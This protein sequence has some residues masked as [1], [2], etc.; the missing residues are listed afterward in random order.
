MSAA[1][2]GP[3]TVSSKELESAIEVLSSA[4][5]SLQ[6]TRFQRLAYQALVISVDAAAASTIVVLLFL[7]NRGDFWNMVIG[8]VF[9]VSV[10]VGVVALALNVP[11]FFKVLRER[12]RLKKLGLSSLSRSLWKESRR[13]RWIRRIRGAVLTAIAIFYVVIFVVGLFVGDRKGGD[14]GFVLG[15]LFVATLA[16]VLFSARYLQ[17]Q[18][19]R[20]DLTASAEELRNALVSLQRR[21]GKAE[22]VSVPS[23]FL[24]QAA[25]IETA[26]IAKE[27]RDAVLQSVAVPSEEYAV[28]FHRDAVEQRASLSIEDR[29]ELEDLVEQLSAHPA[30]LEAQ[31]AATAGAEDATLRGTIKSKRVEIEYVI[32]QASRR[33]RINAVQ[34][35]GVSARTSPKGASH[36]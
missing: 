33:I 19:E 35:G 7:S 13:R 11:L 5:A 9:G 25:K 3:V 34:Q 23:E 14:L 26:Q 30:E 17:N 29:V 32:D 24:E 10:I 22:A 28:V 6:L 8:L 36:A 20:M 1:R 15:A 12:A 21:A 16:A 18:R 4:K 31:A 2:T 27:R